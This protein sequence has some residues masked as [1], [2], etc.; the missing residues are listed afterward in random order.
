MSVIEHEFGLSK[1]HAERRF[2]R[3]LELDALHEANIRANPL[4]HL[5][6]A[7]ERI[8]RL[9]EAMFIA[10]QVAKSGASDALPNETILIS[11]AE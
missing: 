3:L 4:P 7:S 10:I 2:A 9:Q 8:F 5:E 1:R 11:K 6:R